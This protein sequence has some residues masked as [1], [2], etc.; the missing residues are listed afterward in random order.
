MTSATKSLTCIGDGCSRD[1]YCRDLC[2]Y[3]YNK[4]M[5]DPNRN[6]APMAYPCK[7]CGASVAT[8]RTRTAAL[9]RECGKKWRWCKA[10][11][12]PWEIAGYQVKK[13][14]LTLPCPMHVRDEQLRVRLGITLEQYSDLLR[15]QG[16]TCA[17]EGC[18][19]RD[20]LCVDHDHG[21]CP[22]RSACPTC[23]RGLICMRHNHA[24]GQVRDSIAEL[25]ALARYLISFHSVKEASQ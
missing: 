24:L 20:D 13:N 21:C 3:H 17:I 2:A 16:G 5:R 11:G 19:E 9:C 23:I 4:L 6:I 18:E 14:V 15:A 10:C 1:A 8:S 7:L 22:E 25:E 12:G